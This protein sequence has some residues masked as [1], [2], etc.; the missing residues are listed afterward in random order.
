MHDAN[1]MVYAEVGFLTLPLVSAV[2]S[3][4]NHQFRNGKTH[5]AG[6]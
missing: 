3:D 6:L 1:Q 2:S 5:Y 4:L